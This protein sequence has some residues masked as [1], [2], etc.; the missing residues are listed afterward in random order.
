MEM[1]VLVQGGGGEGER[2]RR[3]ER[4]SRGPQDCCCEAA[5]AALT[6]RCPAHPGV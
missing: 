1:Q 6:P 3:W 4:R 5:L 2:E